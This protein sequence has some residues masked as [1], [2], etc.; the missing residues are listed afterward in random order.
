VIFYFLFFMVHGYRDMVFFYRFSADDPSIRRLQSWIWILF[1]ACLLLSLFYVLVP[2]YLLYLSLKPR[3]LSPEY[4]AKVNL[5]MP[6]LYGAL[7]LGWVLLLAAGIGLWRSL[8]R[9]PGGWTNNWSSDRALFLVLIYTTL[10][11]LA[12]PL[13][14]PWVYNMLILSH[15]VGWYFYTSRRLAKLP[16]QS[17]RADGLWQWFRSSVAGFQSLHLGVAAIFL[18]AILINH[19]ALGSTGTLNLLVSSRAFY[20]WTVIHVTISFAPKS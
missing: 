13:V 18:V 6:F 15:F 16:R 9:F 19:F 12:S 7:K 8:K 14:G 10:I 3:H 1:Q 11:I 5:L 17:S 20:Y 4:Q 2:S